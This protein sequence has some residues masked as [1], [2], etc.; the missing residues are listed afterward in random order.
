MVGVR[1][2]GYVRGR[3]CVR[4]VR[5]RSCL[6]ITLT[7]VRVGSGEPAFAGAKV[8]PPLSG[9]GLGYVRGVLSAVVVHKKTPLVM[10]GVNL[11]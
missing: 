9:V 2:R 10:R 8:P 5:G 3:G 7:C 4:Q 1:E 6:V 11:M